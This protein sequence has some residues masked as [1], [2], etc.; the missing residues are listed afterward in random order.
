MVIAT[1]LHD[2]L[3]HMT[4]A[5]A[6]ALLLGSASLHKLRNP[7]GFARVLDDYASAFDGLLPARLRALLSGLLPGLELLAAGGVL[8]SLWQPWAAA[9]AALLLALYAAVLAGAAWRGSAIADCGCHFGSHPQS[10]GWALVVRNLLLLLLALN[11]LAPMGQRPLVWF[12]A[13]TLG[14]ALAGCAA[15]YLLANLLI[16]NRASLREL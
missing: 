6:L 14:F 13:I 15:F 1:C 9:P 8:A 16:S 7:Q 2:P 12:D 10:P 3:V 4:C 5:C 11:L